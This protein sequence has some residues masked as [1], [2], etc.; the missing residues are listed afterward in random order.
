MICKIHIDQFCD[1]LSSKA[2]GLM[3]SRPKNLVFRFNKPKLVYFHS[4]FVFHS[5]YIYTL[6]QDLTIISKQKVHP[7]TLSV[8]KKGRIFLE[9][10]KE[11]NIAD[12]VMFI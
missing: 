7:F 4:F 12:K 10:I 5:F 2:L 8:K 6:N 11:L 1:S 3:F 9:T